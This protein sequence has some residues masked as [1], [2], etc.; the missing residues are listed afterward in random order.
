[1]FSCV[2]AQE[3]VRSRVELCM[4]TGACENACVVVYV[5]TGACEVQCLV[6]SVHGSV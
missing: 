4:H 2:C 6:V 3:Y 1:V 5:H